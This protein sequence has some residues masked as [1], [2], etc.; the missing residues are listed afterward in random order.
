MQSGRCS[1]S[2]SM[3]RNG[4]QRMCIIGAK[5]GGAPFSMN[6]KRQKRMETNDQPVTSPQVFYLLSGDA[7][8]IRSG[9]TGAVG[10][11]FFVASRV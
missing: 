4:H 7:V 11:V 3:E 8:A 2:S 5:L 6:G 1:L 10:T 9:P